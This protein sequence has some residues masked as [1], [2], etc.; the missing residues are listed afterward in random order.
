[1]ANI[2]DDIKNKLRLV[3]ES[4]V[5]QLPIKFEEIVNC[6]QKI[7]ERPKEAPDNLKTLHRLIHSIAGS[8]ATFY[9]PSLGD[10]ARQIEQFLKIWLQEGD[11]LPEDALRNISAQISQLGELTLSALDNSVDTSIHKTPHPTSGENKLI[12]LLDD[13]N[14][15]SEQI[16]LKLTQFGYMVESF[17]TIQTLNIALVK[18]LPAVVISD[19]FLPE[20]EMEGIENMRQYRDDHTSDIPVI[21]ISTNN[22][23]NVR[24]EAVRAGGEAY[25]TKPVNIDRLV[26]RL[27]L[28]TRQKQYEPYRILI[29][30]DDKTL[31]THF[32]LVL[33]QAGMDVFTLTQPERVFDKIASCNPELILMDVYMP[34]CSGMELAKLIRQRDDYIGIPIVYLSTES[35][36]D[37]QLE[38]LHLG[39]DDFLSKPIEDKKLT[40]SLMARVN[41]ARQL[42]SLMNQDSLTGLLRHTKIKAQ[43]AV[44]LSRAKRQNSDMAFIMLDVDHFKNVNDTYGH[45]LGDR[46]LKSLARLLQQR[47]RIT[48]SVGR[49]GGEEFAFI[50]PDTNLENATKVANDIREIFSEVRFSHEGK[51][52][53]VTLSAGISG[54]PQ[55]DSAEKINQSADEALYLAK[56]NGRNCVVIDEGK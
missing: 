55:H 34:D 6:Q 43:L 9:L 5:A 7:L 32:E 11:T 44:E 30:D 54:Y 37:I 36:L 56:K 1:M 13:D 10:K 33:Q 24:L 21:F 8:S 26:E 29:V 35:N 47:L 16:C 18:K 50:M 17:S 20:G 53:A 15:F 41:R 3:R 12:Y 23:F 4:Y 42:N 49:Y 19:I 40:S 2:N 51:E 48:D 25:F 39:G 38:A 46:V 28:L 45:M 27:D 52:F 22:D 14:A 31:C